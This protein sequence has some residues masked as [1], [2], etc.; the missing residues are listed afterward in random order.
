MKQGRTLTELAAEIER[1]AGAKMDLMAD[2]REITLRSNGTSRLAV[3]G[4]GDFGIT[5]MAHGQIAE[6]AGIPKGYYDRMRVEAPALLDGNVNHWLR[7]RPARRLVRTMDGG[8]RAFLSDRYRRLDN[9][10]LMEAVLPTLM[11]TPGLSVA[12]C[13]VT[14]R[15]LYLKVTTDRIQGEVGV[16]DVVQAGLVVS[17]SE[18]GGGAVS[19]QPM[20]LRLV[21][22]NGATHQDFGTRKSHVGRLIS[23]SGE[24]EAFRVFADE[25]LRA[26]DG[27]FFLKVRDVVRAALTQE[28][29]GHILA[30]MREAAGVRIEGDPVRAVEVLAA[31][32]RLTETERTSSLRHLVS[33]GDLSLWGLANAVTA[34]AQEVPSYDRAS[35]ME[36][37]GGSLLA[38]PATDVRALVAA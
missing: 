26:D 28:T 38:L 7:E 4:A 22:R 10:E 16:G 21:C 35:E 18:V 1:Q 17:N 12:S 30:S 37:L 24:G 19:V 36:A 11:E 9:F 25:T 34:M 32:H 14:D 2:T 31:R 20:S 3:A 33:G 27:A 5:D 29:F 13:E 15:R 23:D 6:H 8:A